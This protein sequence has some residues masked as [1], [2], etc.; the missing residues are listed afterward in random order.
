MGTYL[1]HARQGEQVKHSGANLRIP[2]EVGKKRKTI[3]R[4][5]DTELSDEIVLRTPQP[6]ILC[7]GFQGSLKLGAVKDLFEWVEM[8]EESDDGSGDES[9]SC[10]ENDNGSGQESDLVEKITFRENDKIEGER[11]ITHEM[12]I[13]ED[14]AQNDSKGGC[15]ATY[16]KLNKYD[17]STKTPGLFLCGP[18]VRHESLSFCFVY[19]FRQR[20][21]VVSDAIARGLG[22]NTEAAVNDAR[23]MNMFL[24]DFK[25]CKSACGETC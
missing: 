17:E 10:E 14:F 24:D 23:D 4:K 20:F 25:C 16:P 18:A 21:G 15:A 7:L 2:Y 1:V 8:M 22:Y 9:D 19:K 12:S 5:T 3:D 11:R 6:P 13:G